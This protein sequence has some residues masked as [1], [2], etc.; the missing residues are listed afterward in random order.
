IAE[1]VGTPEGKILPADKPELRYLIDSYL[2]WTALQQIP[3]IQG[4]S[5]YLGAV[6]TAPWSRL[7]GGCRAAFLHLRGRGD[8]LA[9]Q[10]IDIPPGAGTDWVR[11]LYDEVFYVLA[12]HGRVSIEGG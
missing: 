5:L 10:L 9:L 2:D 12:G 11:H 8:F 7:G 4:A 3:V 6:E 1:E